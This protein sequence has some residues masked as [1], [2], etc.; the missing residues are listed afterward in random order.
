MSIIGIYVDKNYVTL[1]S[2]NERLPNFTVYMR[3]PTPAYFKVD[4]VEIYVASF[5]SK[6]RAIAYAQLL[7]QE[8]T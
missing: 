5:K 8:P 2:D 1:K 4:Y 3:I 7:A 6:E